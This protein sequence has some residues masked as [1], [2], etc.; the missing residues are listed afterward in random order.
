MT[1]LK[2]IKISFRNIRLLLV[3]GFIC[4]VASCGGGSSSP[5]PELEIETRFPEEGAVD[6]P[7]NIIMSVTFK[8][9]VQ[10]TS[11]EGLSIEISDR[12][13][14]V[15]EGE[16]SLNSEENRITY[17]LNDLL[18]LNTQY[19]V[20]VTKS[21][22]DISD[23][24]EEVSWSWQF[25]TRDGSW[26][27]A[28]L[29]ENNGNDAT[30]PQ[31]VQDN[32]GNRVAIWLQSDGT[33]DNLWS[34]WF[35]PANGQ[36][37]AAQQIETNTGSVIDLPEI[38]QDSQG[39]VTVVWRQQGENNIN[40]WSNR[41][42]RASTEW[43]EAQLIESSSGDVLP[44]YSLTNDPQDNLIVMWRQSDSIQFNLWSNYFSV[45]SGD[46]TGATLIEGS[47]GD[48]STPKWLQDSNGNITAIWQQAGNISSNRFIVGDARWGEDT[49]VENNA[50]IVSMPEMAQDEEGNITVIWT[51]NDGTENNLWSNRFAASNLEWA[52]ASLI[53]ENTGDVSSPQIVQDIEGNNV[54][55]WRQ[56]GTDTENLWSSRISGEST[57]WSEPEQIET[58]SDN[59]STDIHLTIDSRGNAMALWHQQEDS[60]LSLWSNYF[61]AEANN[62]LTAQAIESLSTE[63]IDSEL[64]DS[65]LDKSLAV[66]IQGD[67]TEKNLWATLFD[68]ATNTWATP[69][70]VDTSNGDVLEFHILQDKQ[71]NAI[72]VW[73][74]GDS[75]QKDLWVS[76][77]DFVVNSWSAAQLIENDTGDVSGVQV[78]QNDLG[79]SVIIW[80]Q[81][82]GTRN[83][84]WSVRF[85]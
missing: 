29:L 45:E 59:V 73:T 44:N 70:L 24:T 68:Q 51:Q 23:Q 6:V 54:V 10:L 52:A 13:S 83:N 19:N 14:N 40:L 80:S 42:D 79:N 36:W 81:N 32:Q 76:Q 69:Q 77:F 62:W 39:N 66:W 50:G 61:D 21:P 1:F 16:L 7:Q 3:I 64:L 71:G 58:N 41:F 74:Q 30:S 25:N 43:A 26:G 38:L 46:W 75:E 34:S 27:T 49:L 33:Q 82:D 56:T 60:Q 20:V 84:I 48:A 5:P 4:L 37:A 31:V 55:V 35:N 15:I 17:T 57:N 63:V 67:Q 9:S 53:E 22:I 78:Q 85:E 18:A 12:Q 72:L 28:E 8:N 65:N 47:D 2:P 11:L